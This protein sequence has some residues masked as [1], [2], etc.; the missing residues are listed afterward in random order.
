[1]K[2]AFL[3]L[4]IG[5]LFLPAVF[6]KPG[7]TMY[8]NVKESTLKSGTNFFSSKNGNVYYGDPIL[9]LE[10]S[11]RWS[12]VQSLTNPSINGWV[13][14]A[15]LTRKKIVQGKTGEFSEKEL[16]L[17]G[18]GFSAEVEGAMQERHGELRFDLVDQIEKTTISDDILLVFLTEGNLL[19]GER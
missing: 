6:A 10:E 8:V 1:M 13:S 7:D 2:K 11:G 19:G 3:L 14:S 16:A 17:A 4:Y 12:K 18:K 5:L 9:V 15:N